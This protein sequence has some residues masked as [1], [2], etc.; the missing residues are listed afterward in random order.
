MKQTSVTWV[1]T[2][3]LSSAEFIPTMKILSG[4]LLLLTSKHHDGVLWI[5]SDANLTIGNA[6]FTG[7]SANVLRQLPQSARLFELVAG[8]VKR[9]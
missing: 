8:E 4:I 5:T 9:R 2:L 7:D 1:I 6:K 3:A